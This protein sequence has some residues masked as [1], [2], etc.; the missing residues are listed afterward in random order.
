MRLTRSLVTIAVA[1][2]L[3]A[4][5]GPAS[6]AEPV[7][8][9]AAWIVTPASLLPILFAHQGLAKHEGTSYT[10]DPIHFNSSPTQITALASGDVEIGTLNFA[11]YPYAV[12]NAKLNLRIIADDTEDG[13]D[14]YATVQYEVLRHSGIRTIKDLKG[15]ELGVIGIGAATDIAMRTY[16]RRNG[17]NYPGDYNLIEVRPPTAKAMLFE[18]KVDLVNVGLPLM[19]DPEIEAQARTLFTMKQAFGAS[20]LSFMVAREDFLKAHRA[21]VVDFLEDAVRAYRWYADP[22]NH[23]EASEILA[24]FTKMPLR[25]IRAWAFTKKGPYRNPDGRPDLAMV[26]RDV[27]AMQSLGFIKSK[28]EIKPYADLSLVKEADRRLKESARN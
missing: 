24:R 18:H 10:F 17:L 11:S 23:D 5:C 14:G 28:L 7:K 21:A 6:R 12:L 13:Y 27:D 2:M 22:A 3:A 8:I 26:Q 9:R 20:A 16:L 19:Y 4:L 15:K 1:A 25:D